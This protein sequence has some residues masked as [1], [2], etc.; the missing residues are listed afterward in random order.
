MKR[1]SE[2]WVFSYSNCVLTPECLHTRV[3]LGRVRVGPPVTRDYRSRQ[4]RLHHHAPLVLVSTSTLRSQKAKAQTLGMT[5]L[6]LP[7]KA[8]RK[9]IAKRRN[10]GPAARLPQ[11]ER[12][13]ARCIAGPA[14]P[15]TT[16]WASGG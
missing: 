4:Q 8:S 7:K 12:L 9:P 13:C 2:S 5:K 15:R 6:A 11:A 16:W 1:A 3:P 10:S 14:L